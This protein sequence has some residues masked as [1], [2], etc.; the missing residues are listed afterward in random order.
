MTHW[1]DTDFKKALLEI[2]PEEKVA[3]EGMKFVE[4]KDR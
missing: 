4:I 1:H 2:A 3:I